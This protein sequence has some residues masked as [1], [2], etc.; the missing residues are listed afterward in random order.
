MG[1]PPFLIASSMSGVVAQRLVRLICRNCREELPQDSPEYE[2]AIARLGLENGFP[3]F[4]GVGCEKCN[5][6]G[7]RGRIAILELLVVD[8]ETRRAI[9]HK[10]NSGDLRDIAVRNGMRTLWQDGLDKLR[11]GLTTAD[12][13]ARVLLGTEDAAEEDASPEM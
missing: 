6:S 11:T 7:S 3:L 13:V 9:M 2:A 4:H 12:E 5:D 8:R 10:T 1:V